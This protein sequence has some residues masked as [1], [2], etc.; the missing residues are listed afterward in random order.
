MERLK[1]LLRFLTTIDFGKVRSLSHPSLLCAAGCVPWCG[2]CARAYECVCV[3]VCVDC[4]DWHG[5]HCLCLSFPAP[6]DVSA[7][8][9]G[10]GERRRA[11]HRRERAGPGHGCGEIRLLPHVRA[12]G[13]IGGVCF[14]LAFAVMSAAQAQH[15]RCLCACSVTETATEG[16]RC[17]IGVCNAS[18]PAT[19]RFSPGFPGRRP[20]PWPQGCSTDTSSIRGQ[21]PGSRQ[22]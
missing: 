14:G 6:G 5:H 21:A 12:Q 2:L 9:R 20:H 13:E 18:A 4:V 8:V 16:Q 17:R 1:P 10:R 3:C 22:Q 15:C 11:G 19:T 7:S